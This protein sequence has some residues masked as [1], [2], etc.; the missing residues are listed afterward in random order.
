MAYFNQSTLS[1][2]SKDGWPKESKKINDAILLYDKINDKVRWLEEV[3]VESRLDTNQRQQKDANPG[4]QNGQIRQWDPG[5][6]LAE[7]P[8][9]DHQSTTSSGTRWIAGAILD[10]LK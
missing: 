2:E 7:E 1:E 8:D 3:G 5:I 6:R 4:Q 10:L 9:S